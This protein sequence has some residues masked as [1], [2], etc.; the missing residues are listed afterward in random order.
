M[1]VTAAEMHKTHENP[2]I[3]VDEVARWAVN[4]RIGRLFI[5]KIIG[6]CVRG[7]PNVVTSKKYHIAGKIISQH[8]GG[9]S[10]TACLNG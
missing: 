2:D 8:A 3:S 6:S 7:K 10:K 9:C 4:Y 5:D 1:P